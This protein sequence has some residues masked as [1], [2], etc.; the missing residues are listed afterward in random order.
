MFLFVKPTL[1]RIILTIIFGWLL[2]G[3]IS[4]PNPDVEHLCMPLPVLGGDLRFQEP[5]TSRATFLALAQLVRSGGYV[6]QLITPSQ[7]LALTIF[8]YMRLFLCVLLSYPVACGVLYAGSRL[9]G[10]SARQR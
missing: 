1:F 10:R 2:A 6:C 3:Y 8:G 7:Q 5:I 4:L 9:G